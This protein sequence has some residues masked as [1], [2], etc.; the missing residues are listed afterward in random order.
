MYYNLRFII[1]SIMEYKFR[2]ELLAVIETSFGVLQPRLL[3]LL[4]RVEVKTLRQTNKSESEIRILQN[5]IKS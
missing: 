5:V 1:A 2:E 4:F 3:P